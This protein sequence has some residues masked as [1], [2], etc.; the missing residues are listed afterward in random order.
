VPTPHRLANYLTSDLVSIN[1]LE[2]V[3]D[4]DETPV[5]SAL[6]TLLQGTLVLAP[7]LRWKVRKHAHGIGEVDQAVT[8]RACAHTWGALQ[9]AF[10][11]VDVIQLRQGISTCA[12]NMAASVKSG[13]CS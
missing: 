4:A 2:G 11:V 6:C 3:C 1:D 13:R 9:T 10:K 8:I 7:N 12:P 5:Y